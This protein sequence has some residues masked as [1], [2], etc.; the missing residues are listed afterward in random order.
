MTDI[1]NRKQVLILL[2]SPFQYWCAQEYLYQASLLHCNI[3]VINAATFCRHSMIQIKRLHEN[4]SRVK[5]VIL[6][7]PK[8]GSLTSRIAPYADLAKQ[9]QHIKFDLILVGDLRQIWMQ[10]IACSLDCE[11]IVLV[12]DGAATN[13]FVEKLIAP[14]NFKLPVS[15][16]TQCP[17]RK[18]E[19][20]N[21]KQALGLNIVEKSMTLFSIFTFPDDNHTRLNQLSALRARFTH[22]EKNDEFHF[23][24]SPV[25]EKGILGDDDYYKMIED[26]L[27][28]SRADNKPVYFAHRAEA[29][30][31]KKQKLEALGFSV[32]LHDE[33]Y[34]LLCASAGRVPAEIA[35]MHSTSLF[36][37]KILFAEQISASCYLMDETRL[38]QFA[39]QH[40]GSDKFTL[41]DHIESI[42]RRL[43]EFNIEARLAN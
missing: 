17:E 5:E 1:D 20:A 40:W 34:E 43:D 14:A 8:A 4:C 16:H 37:M 7:I 28:S 26:A 42:Y 24:G 41:R 23:I 39:T 33:P 19:A 30:E 6:T 13:V 35:G 15:M 29:L 18:Q 25:V 11:N 9:L 32:E 38:A 2:S 36:N 31:S 22:T 3:T 21:I 10:D 12:D 27:R